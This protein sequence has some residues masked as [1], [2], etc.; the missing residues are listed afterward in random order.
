MEIQEFC[1]MKSKDIPEILDE[2]WM[3]G[4]A[5]AV[6]VTAL[7]NELKGLLSLNVHPSEGVS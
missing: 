1:T 4:F 5:F 3:A 7:M 6:D 2:D